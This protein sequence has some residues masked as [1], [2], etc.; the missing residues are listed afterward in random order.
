MFA[1]FASYSCRACHCLLRPSQATNGSP[2]HPHPNLE[3]TARLNLSFVPKLEAGEEADK[4][5]LLL[6]LEASINSIWHFQSRFSVRLARVIELIHTQNTSAA[7]F[8]LPLCYLEPCYLQSFKINFYSNFEAPHTLLD[9]KTCAANTCLA[10]YDIPPF[11]R[12]KFKI[13][14]LGSAQMCVKKLL[15]LSRSLTLFLPHQIPTPSDR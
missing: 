2:Q 13:W 5:H 10:K 14:L 3:T 15:C 1:Q 11:Y 7:H 8:A 6:H 9:S 12:L 4:L